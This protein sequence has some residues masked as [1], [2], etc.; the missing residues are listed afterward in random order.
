MP[1]RTGTIATSEPCVRVLA[2]RLEAIYPALATD[3]LAELQV[4]VAREWDVPSTAAFGHAIVN[5]FALR[6]TLGPWRPDDRAGNRGFA[7]IHALAGSAC[8]QRPGTASRLWRSVQLPRIEPGRGHHGGRWHLACADLGGAEFS[9]EWLPG[10]LMAECRLANAKF[11]DCFAAGAVFYRADA[12]SSSW[13]RAILLYG[14][15]DRASLQSSRFAEADLS[16]A[17]F[18]SANLAGADLSNVRARLARFLHAD[19]SDADLHGADLAAA[20][21]RECNLTGADLTGANLA[22]AQLDGARYDETTRW[23]D[24]FTPPEPRG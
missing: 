9:G 13:S 18:A 21:L 20:D 7:R 15:F 4:Q 19:L 24:G 16:K 8:E 5:L 14:V 1:T 12:P 6:G 2:E 17:S 10:S 11:D 3:D 23:P 22:H